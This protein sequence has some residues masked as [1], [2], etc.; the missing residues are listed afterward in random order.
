MNYYIDAE[1]ASVCGEYMILEKAIE[2]RR[3]IMNL[4]KIHAIALVNE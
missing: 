1:G 3:K 2:P 4:N